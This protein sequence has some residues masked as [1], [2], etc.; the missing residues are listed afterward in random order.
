MSWLG[1]L[2][3]Q[4]TRKWLFG[5]IASDIAQTSAEMLQANG[6]YISIFVR[7]IHLR[8]VRVNATRYHGLVAS[9][10]R[11]L[12]G[13]GYTEIPNNVSPNPL[14]SINARHLDHIVVGTIRILGP[15]PYRGGDLSIDLALLSV[16]EENFAAPFLDLLT[17]LSQVAG[18]A[19]LG[20]GAP[21]IAPMIKG[22]QLLADPTNGQATIEIGLSTTWDQPRT[23]DY[24]IARTTKSDA[25]DLRLK[26]GYTISWADGS[27]LEDPYIVIS[28]TSSNQRDDWEQIPEILEAW[29]DIRAAVRAGDVERARWGLNYLRRVSVM[30][31]DLLPK[32]ANRLI[33]IATEAVTRAMPDTPTGIT[34]R[35]IPPLGELPLYTSSELC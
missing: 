17:E 23:G 25:A 3:R 21:F 10:C 7:S 5:Q 9:S 32:D 1:G 11:L 15:R 26:E 2:L 12:T 8:N 13:S 31:S 35:V 22:L 6:S 30:S 24:V 19:F 20:A 29:D 14:R 33:T 27:P 28:V 16:P 18:V 34:A 4:P